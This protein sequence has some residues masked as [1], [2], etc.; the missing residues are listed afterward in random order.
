[1]LDNVIDVNFYPTIETQTANKRHRP[2]GLGLMGVQDIFYKMDIAFGSD[3]AVQLSDKIMEF[4]SFHAILES[5]H[6]AAERGAYSSYKGSKWDRD[7]FPLDTII[8]AG[9]KVIF[10]AEHL[11]LQTLGNEVSLFDSANKS[12]AQITTLPGDLALNSEGTIAL[13]DW[14]KFATEY[15]RLTR[16]NYSPLPL[17]I[18]PDLNKIATSSVAEIDLNSNVPLVAAVASTPGFWGKLFHPIRTI[19][20]SFY[21]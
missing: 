14:E 8:S 5:S 16:V 20:E 18:N 15:W 17:A 7:I 12:I 6:L 13:T 9:E 10:P 1:M 2:V 3:E 21:K 11:K 4:I 19:Q